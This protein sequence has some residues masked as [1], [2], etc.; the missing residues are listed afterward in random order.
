MSARLCVL[1][2]ML[3]L[4]VPSAASAA[5]SLTGVSSPVVAH[6][7]A[8]AGQQVAIILQRKPPARKAP[9]PKRGG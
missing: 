7:A 4:V 1:T 8:P 5:P 6:Q 3:A 2:A 9:P